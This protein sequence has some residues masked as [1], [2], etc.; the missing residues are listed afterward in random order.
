MMVSVFRPKTTLTPPT[1]CLLAETAGD[2][3]VGWP[4]DTKTLLLWVWSIFFGRRSAGG[5]N[6]YRGPEFWTISPTNF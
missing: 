6:A 2:V 3:V 5:F 1:C 4:F